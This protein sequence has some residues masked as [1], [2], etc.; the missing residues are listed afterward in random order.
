MIEPLIQ[1]EGNNF[2]IGRGLGKYWGDYFTKLNKEIPCQRHLYYDYREWLQDTNIDEDRGKLLTDMVRQFPSLFDELVGMTIGINESKIGFEVTI[3]GLFTCWLAETDLC[4]SVVLKTSDGYFLAH[5]DEY[6]GQY[7]MVVADVS[8]EVKKGKTKY[9]HSVSH[10]FQL[11]GSAVGMNQN[12]AFQGNSI[13][14]NKDTLKKLQASWDKRIPK[15]VF[16]RM[17]LEMSTIDEIEAIYQKYPSTLPNHHYVIF[18]DKAY[19]VEVIPDSDKGVEKQKLNNDIHVQTNHFLSNT[20]KKW[21]CSGFEESK[22]RRRELGS[23]M[24]GVNTAEQ[25]QEKF[26]KFLKTYKQEGEILVKRTSGSFFFTVQK[27]KPLSCEVHLFYGKKEII[28]C[29]AR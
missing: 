2:E 8:L 16:T 24:N 1:L 21:Q 5:S 23:T 15:T 12:F 18:P 4:S 26:I 29:K 11:L 28:S 27:D 3:F 6:D 9:F 10:P 7:P 17:M 19:S 20:S 14:C 13:G 22:T 25:V